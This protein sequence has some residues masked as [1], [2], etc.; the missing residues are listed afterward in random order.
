MYGVE[1]SVVA[2]ARPDGT[3]DGKTTLD[4]KGSVGD[5]DRG[6]EGVGVPVVGIVLFRA[7]TVTVTLLGRSHAVCHLVSCLISMT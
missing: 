7:G 2:L 4:V 6:I 3:A 1:R 5:S